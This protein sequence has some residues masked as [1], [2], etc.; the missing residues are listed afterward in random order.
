[1][2]SFGCFSARSLFSFVFRL[3]S[4]SFSLTSSFDAFS[5]SASRLSN[6]FIFFSL[7]NNFNCSCAVWVSLVCVTDRVL[8]LSLFMVILKFCSVFSSDSLL[9]IS[10]RLSVLPVIVSVRLFPWLLTMSFL[11][12]DSLMTPIASH[13]LLNFR[14]L[15]HALDPFL[16]FSLIFS[17]V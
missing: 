4:S 11:K 7:S 2:F 9:K 16:R 13:T 8:L 10:K 1:M 6:S 12:I 17:L 3:R 5:F 14:N 15:C